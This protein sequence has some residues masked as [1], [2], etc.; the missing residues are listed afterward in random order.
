MHVPYEKQNLFIYLFAHFNEEKHE[1]GTES[2]PF[3]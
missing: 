2:L 1:F 3:G